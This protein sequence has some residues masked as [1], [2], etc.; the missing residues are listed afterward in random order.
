MLPIERLYQLNRKLPVWM[1]LG[2]IFSAGVLLATS[3]ILNRDKAQ[4]LDEANTKGEL[5]A[6][7]LENHLT[8]TLSSIDNSL[9]IISGILNDQEAQTPG[10]QTY[11]NISRFLEVTASNSTH[12]RSISILDTHGKILASSAV[13]EIG[14]H[15]NL[16]W[17]GFNDGLTSTLEAGRPVFIR[18]I[19]ELD[20]QGFAEENPHNRTHALPFAKQI[21]VGSMDVVMLT[22]I[23]PQY[24]L[25]NFND[26][27]G[28]KVNFVTLFDYRGKVLGTTDNEH[29]MLGKNYP[30][31]PV[32]SAIQKDAEFGS[33]HYVTKTADNEDSYIFNFR[34]PRQ[35]PI[36]LVT[37]ISETYAISQWY[38]NSRN[39]KWSGLIV[40]GFVLLCATLLTWFMRSRDRFEAELELSKIRAEQANN[41]KSAFISTMSHEIRTP[42]NGVIGMTNLLM[43]TPLDQRQKEFLKVIDESANALMSIINDILD[44]SKIEAGKMQI[45]HSECDLVS[46]VEACAEILTERAELKDIRLISFIDP[47][48][49]GI[50]STDPGRL[51]QILLNLIGNAIK[52]TDAGEVSIDVRARKHARHQTIRFEI[53]DTGIGIAPE[54][55][56]HLFTPF[57]QADGSITRRFGGTGL[58]LSICKRLVELMEGEIGVNSEQGKGSVFWF[59][60]PLH[61]V[62]NK[63]AAIDVNLP[64]TELRVL[65]CL[66]NR[67]LSSAIV[68]YLKSF[69]MLPVLVTTEEDMRYSLIAYPDIAAAIIDEVDD[70]SFATKTAQKIHRD[71]PQVPII[72]IVRTTANAEQS[73]DSLTSSFLR[74]PVKQAMLR[75]AVIQAKENLRSPKPDPL[76]GKDSVLTNPAPPVLAQKKRLLLVEDNLINQKVALHLL[77][78]MGYL[79]DLAQNG[80]ECLEILETGD[81]ALILMDCQMPVMDGFEATR[82]I[83]HLEKNQNTHIPVIALTAN[84]MQEEKSLCLAAGMDD[85]LAKPI[86]RNDLGRMLQ[87]YWPQAQSALMPSENLRPENLK[88]V[89]N[90]QRLQEITDNDPEMQTVLLNMYADSTQSVLDALSVAISQ[91]DLQK[92]SQIGHQLKGAS[93]NLGLLELDA[94]ANEL[95]AITQHHDMTRIHALQT[96]LLQAFQRFTA[97]LATFR[98]TT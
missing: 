19:Q 52:F 70:A 63:P 28:P 78:Q 81:Y 82:Q 41:A 66:P 22:M 37:A 10:K 73:R 29:F 49:P 43:E 97:Y 91:A 15:I 92:I 26:I 64:E 85:Y 30:E 20:D 38:N 74:Q 83:R 32:F 69:G 25:A 33:L 71:A 93:G 27:I 17:M 5:L 16:H 11:R 46:I 65:L 72:R 68:S 35:Y 86:N 84:V 7:M 67:T 4:I 89:I 39:L 24:L 23:N 2:V 79:A 34:T 14:R 94:L 57:T 87:Q 47:K 44:F 3:F 56:A 90:I 55:M 48:L 95:E 12:L 54:V 40:A 42:M 9:N 60:I 1:I 80:K 96:S 18:D 98:V 75:T 21:R 13:H 8:R 61:S 50:I 6:R 53:R 62:R 51:R 31:L 59:E 76:S 45:D 58:G 77:Q 36:V 88:D